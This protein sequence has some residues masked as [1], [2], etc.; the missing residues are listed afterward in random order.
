MPPARGYHGT[1]EAARKGAR[2]GTAAYRKA[3]ATNQRVGLTS[4][5]P[6]TDAEAEF[7]RA[8]EAH[9]SRL[10]KP[11]LRAVDYFDV[12]IGLGYR[13]VEDPS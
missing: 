11:F 7:L 5:K 2:K 8:A 3:R 10:G 1:K 13:K 9:R 12:L 6:Y 4:D